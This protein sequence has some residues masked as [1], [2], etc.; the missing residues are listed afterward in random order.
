MRNASRVVA[1]WLVIAL[2]A[3]PVFAQEPA[4]P[5]RAS[6]ER[7]A[8][9]AG[10]A[11]AAA[12]QS[13]HHPR[14]RMFW[15]GIALG[16]AGV[17]TSVLGVTVARVEDSSTGNAPPGSY[18]ACVAQK[19]ADPIYATNDC[20]AL[21][22]KNLALLWSGVTISA[23]GAALVVGSTRTRAEVSAGTF[24]VFHTVRF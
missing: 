3:A 22:G 23:V 15:P 17:T 11:T 19:A 16:V 1:A 10:P 2:T 7:A 13:D 21:K 4:T 6:A 24:G 5:I 8:A 20:G 18:R 12:E 9:L 14:G